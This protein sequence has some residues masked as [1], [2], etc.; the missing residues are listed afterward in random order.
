MRGTNARTICKS[1][2][3]FTCF[4]CKRIGGFTKKNNKT[5]NATYKQ[6]CRNKIHHQ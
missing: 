4:I 5:G 3:S 1:G 6:K 2:S